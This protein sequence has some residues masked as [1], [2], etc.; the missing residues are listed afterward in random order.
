MSVGELV[1]QGHPFFLISDGFLCYDRTSMYTVCTLPL[2]LVRRIEV[3][4][5]FTWG[6]DQFGDFVVILCKSNLTAQAHVWIDVSGWWIDVSSWWI[7][8]RNRS[9]WRLYRDIVLVKCDIASSRFPWIVTLMFPKCSL[10]FFWTHMWCFHLP[11]KHIWTARFPSSN[12]YSP[13]AKFTGQMANG[14]CCMHAS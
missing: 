5:W 11:R 1:P 9:V 12:V 8:V 6:I 2:L 7:H 13:M 3:S 14:S 4:A 10:N